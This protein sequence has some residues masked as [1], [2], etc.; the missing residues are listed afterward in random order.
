MTNKFKNLH[1]WKKAKILVISVYEVTDKFPKQ[2]IFGLTSQINRAAVSILANIA[3]GSSRASKKDF[4][5]FLE[6]SLG[7][8]FEVESLLV[9]SLERNYLNQ[10]FYDKLNNQLTE[11]EKIISG[12][13][14]RLNEK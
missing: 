6:I 11:V 9:I 5:R 7:S 2:E 12:L 13:I 1:A 4:S 10:E 14:R 3:E 8:A